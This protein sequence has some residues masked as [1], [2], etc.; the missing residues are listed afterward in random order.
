MLV[1]VRRVSAWLLARGV[2]VCFRWIPSEWNTADDPSRLAE[3]IA[4]GTDLLEDVLSAQ[5]SGPSVSRTRSVDTP[6]DICL[7]PAVDTFQ[8]GL[9]S[10][11]VLI[12]DQKKNDTR[13]DQAVP[14]RDMRTDHDDIVFEQDDCES[15]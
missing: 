9:D 4:S 13:S 5:S 10:F 1:Q 11:T 3:K 8:E 2:R 6:L 14:D 12:H 7:A 15:A